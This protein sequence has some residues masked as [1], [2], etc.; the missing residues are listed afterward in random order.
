MSAQ[1]ENKGTN[2]WKWIM[3]GGLVI[4]LILVLSVYA[5][6]AYAFPQGKRQQAET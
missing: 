5:L 1:A 6:F 2:T 3:G 4:L